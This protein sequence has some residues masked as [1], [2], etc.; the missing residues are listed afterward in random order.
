MQLH[1][2]TYPKANTR[3]KSTHTSRRITPRPIGQGMPGWIRDLA[4]FLVL[5]QYAVA[6]SSYPAIVCG[7]GP[8]LFH[9]EPLTPGLLHSGARVR[10][11]DM[12]PDATENQ[13][14]SQRAAPFFVSL[15]ENNEL[16]D[17]NP[18]DKK[19]WP[20]A[21]E[22]AAACSLLKNLPFSSPC[23]AEPAIRA[24][25]AAPSAIPSC[26]ETWCSSVQE[27]ARTGKP[28]CSWS[29][30]FGQTEQSA[31]RSCDLIA[32][33][34][35]RP[36]IPTGRLRWLRSGARHILNR[37]VMSDGGVIVPRVRSIPNAEGSRIITLT[38]RLGEALP[39]RQKPSGSWKALG[40]ADCRSP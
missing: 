37:S 11:G 32:P 8:G 16:T 1:T 5:C 24:L 17:V 30:R 19:I 33:D 31:D 23:C 4:I 3:L 28:P 21:T 6:G 38:F 7:R 35:R 29:P 34:V 10:A 9:R 18:D 27:P 22:S 14:G 2:N 39:A 20:P 12:N 25:I 26:P 13:K 40:P 15:T 36:G